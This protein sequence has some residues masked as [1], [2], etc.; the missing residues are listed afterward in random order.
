MLALCSLIFPECG[1]GG[2]GSTG[3]YETGG[4]GGTGIVILKNLGARKTIPKITGI[5]FTSSNIVFTVQQDSGTSITHV[6]YTINGG[7]EVST[8]VGTLSVAH[9]LSSSAAI[10]VVAWAVDTSGN[11]LS[12]KKTVTGTIP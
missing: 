10:S 8:A 12:A 1:G 6:K 3:S 2:G 9:S 4:N 5:S 11:Q 7:S